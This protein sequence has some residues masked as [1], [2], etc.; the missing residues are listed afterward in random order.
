MPF[1]G[2]VVSI[3]TSDARITPDISPQSGNRRWL[4][5]AVIAISQLLIVLDATIT[6]IAL[7]TAQKALHITDANRQWVITTYALAFGDSKQ[8]ALTRLHMREDPQPAGPK[9]EDL[10]L[11]IR[12]ILKT[13]ASARPARD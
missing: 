5:L 9:A 13:Q 2:D 11:E 4:A 10:L 8:A 7:P 1:W 12:D 3:T 6:T